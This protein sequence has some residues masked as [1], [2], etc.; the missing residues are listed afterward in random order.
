M[1]RPMSQVSRNVALT[2][3]LLVALAST[4]ACRLSAAESGTGQH[5]TWTEAM[6]AARATCQTVQ[7]SGKTTDGA[8]PFESGP[9]AGD[10]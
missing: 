2:A 6:L 1:S 5:P 7:A 4:L 10:G 8:T 9:I 3:T